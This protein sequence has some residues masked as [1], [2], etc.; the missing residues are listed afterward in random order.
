MT[1]AFEAAL[2]PPAQMEGRV[3]CSDSP[4]FPSSDS[5]QFVDITWAPLEPSWIFKC[6]L[7]SFPEI[8][9]EKDVD[10]QPN[11]EDV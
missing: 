3:F 11:T 5:V 4:G 8:L 9:K 2:T 1:N 7:Y 10:L 6:T